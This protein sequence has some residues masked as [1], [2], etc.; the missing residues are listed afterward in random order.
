MWRTMSPQENILISDLMRS[1]LVPF[2]MKQQELDDQLT[3]NVVIVF[4]TYNLKAWLRFAP[5]RG[6][7]FLASYCMYLFSRCY[8]ELRDTNTNCVSSDPQLFVTYGIRL[9][10]VWAVYSVRSCV[11]ADLLSTREGNPSKGWC[12]LPPLD[13][14]VVMVGIPI[15]VILE[16]CTINSKHTFTSCES[17]IIKKKMQKP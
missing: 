11:C 9:W 16:R 10:L 3:A 17:Y 2:G 6:K 7:I 15:C 12:P 1:L 8:V 14:P 4:E 13:P 5:R